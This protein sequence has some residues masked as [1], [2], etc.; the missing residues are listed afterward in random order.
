MRTTIKGMTELV[1][2]STDIL[3]RAA[4]CCG[5]NEARDKGNK[6]GKFYLGEDGHEQ[7]QTAS[8]AAFC[9]EPLVQVFQLPSWVQMTRSKNDIEIALPKGLRLQLF[10][11]GDSENKS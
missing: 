4:N 8:F 6:M 10:C 2:A 7:V 9:K 11:H 1:P 5:K 3:K